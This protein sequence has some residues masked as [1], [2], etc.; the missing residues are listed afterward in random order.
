MP[1]PQEPY[2][3]TPVFDET[4]LPK[5]LQKAHDTKAGTWGVLELMAGELVYVV[6]GTG[7]RRVMQ[8]GDCQLIEPQQLHHVELIG[9]MQ[10]Q[11]H[12]YR[13]PPEL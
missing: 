1:D 3:S 6:E 4:S 8:A 11:V 10:M 5:A 12:F 13:Q 7:C 9:P 2:S